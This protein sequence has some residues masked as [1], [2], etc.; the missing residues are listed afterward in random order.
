MSLAVISGTYSAIMIG[1]SLLSA[2]FIIRKSRAR[3]G[4]TGFCAALVLAVV[5]VRAKSGDLFIGSAG[6]AGFF[7]GIRR[8]NIDSDVIGF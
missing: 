3:L 7:Q 1:L 6:G 4:A 8:I 2:V 5:Y